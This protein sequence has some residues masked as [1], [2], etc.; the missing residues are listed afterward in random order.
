M[1]ESKPRWEK[2]Y[3]EYTSQSGKYQNMR[4][5][6]KALKEGKVTGEFKTKEEYQKAVDARAKQIAEYEKELNGYEN[7][8]KNKDKIQNI[9]EYRNGLIE[10]LSKL[11]KARNEEETENLN[12]KK[13]EQETK[14]QRIAQYQKE[15]DELRQQLKNELSDSD[16]QILLLTLKT[17]MDS[18]GILQEEQA[19]LSREIAALEEIG[20]DID[21]ETQRKTATYERKIA[22]C[23]IIAA[24]LLK[25]KELGEFEIKVIPEDKKL[26]SSDGKLSEEVEKARYEQEQT[27]AQENVEETAEKLEDSAYNAPEIIDDAME[28]AE[29]DK[30]IAEVNT[31]A[32]KHPRLAQIANFFK[33]MGSR[34]ANLFKRKDAEELETIEAELVEENNKDDLFEEIEENVQKQVESEKEEASAYKETSAEDLEED[35]DYD[36]AEFTEMLRRSIKKGKEQSAPK[37][38]EKSL[39]E[40]E[41]E[42]LKAIAEKGQAKA[43]R[44]KLAVN[45]QQSANNY[46]TKYG[47]VYEKQDRETTVKKDEGR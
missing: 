22:K 18:M 4:M 3:E 2:K 17:K 5:Y 39:E 1:K 38:A 47:G 15:I 10:K 33:T 25:G 16:K 14:S 35:M 32:Q 6:I 31:F 7:F 19:N 41:N 44:E 42:M 20:K 24:N 27:V 40:A 45:K 26:K 46:A 37:K 21:E 9:L 11:P 29:E 23:N 43:F 12:N 28:N 36:Y 34:V 8:K 30:A 13:K